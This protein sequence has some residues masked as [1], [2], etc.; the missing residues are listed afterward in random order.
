MKH[1]ARIALLIVATTWPVGAQNQIPST[2]GENTSMTNPTAASADP[3]TLPWLVDEKTG[4][5]YQIQTLAKVPGAFR[6]LDDTHVRFPGGAVFEIIDHDDT[7]FR[8]KAYEPVFDSMTKV[9]TK[10]A[11]AT[12]EE[13]ARAA[14]AYKYQMADVD[15]LK[16][17]EFDR[18]LPRQ[19]QWRNG[20]DLADMN[21]DGHLDIV[22]GP[23]RKSRQRPN[24]FLGDSKG[25]WKFWSEAQ[26]QPLGY[27]YGDV[28][29][30]DWNGDKIPDLAFGVHLKG[31][32]AV[33]NDGKD[34]FV[35]YTKGIEFDQPGQGGDATSFSSRAIDTIDWNSDGRIDLIA[36]GEGPKGKKMTPGAAGNNSLINTAR[37]LRI[38]LN[39]GD[40]TWKPVDSVDPD[41]AKPNFGD[42]FAVADLNHDKK[43]DVITGTRQL[44]NEAIV[45][46]GNAES[47]VA[48][49]QFPGLRDRA[50]V[51]AVA[52]RDLNAD[53]KPDIVLAYQNTEN[54]IWRTGIDVYLAGKVGFERRTI[55]SR[56]G[57]R[58]NISAID[59]GDI[60]GD[61]HLDLAVATG[62][63]EVFVFLG[64][65]KGGFSSEVSAELPSTPKPGCA[66]F[67][68]RLADLDRDGRAE[69]IAAFAGEKAGPGIAGI[70]T[71][72]CPGEGSLRVWT[73]T[74][75]VSAAQ[76]SAS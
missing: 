24:I 57:R 70:D 27:D 47:K 19:D 56:E 22:F 34:N 11:A 49:E 25:N 4:A 67:D 23:A 50:L 65:G 30:G 20:L 21:R 16:F 66:G 42:D 7:N 72:G 6:W 62:Q 18:G 1:L 32:L 9:P 2:T 41:Y 15:R 29:V 40:G 37:G 12:P 71:E 45:A 5:R 51:P 26:F 3:A 43:L 39:N 59:L 17:V 55:V 76:K 52:V 48:F 53:K 46:Y 64:D 8:V 36:F 28:A 63:F 68:V 74:P 38:Y 73:P 61:G 35:P 33:V 14:E 31:M 75:T 54:G 13:L 69:L 60:D 44:G 58:G 10:K